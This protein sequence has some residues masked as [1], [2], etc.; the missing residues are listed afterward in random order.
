VKKFSKEE[1]SWI[2]YDWANSA[3]ATIMLAA[4]FPVFFVGM[5]G[6]EGTPGSMW[7]A[8]GIAIARLVLGIAAPVIGA[9]IAYKGYKMR[10]FVT[11]IS[12][13][14][15]F[16]LFL[17]FQ[18][19]WQMLLVGYILA[20]IF[21]SASNIIYD[22]YLPDVTT[23]DRMDKVSA[24]GY[25]MG[26]I[27]GSTI[28]F[29]ISIILIMFGEQFPVPIDNTMAVRISIVMTA[30]WWGIFSIP[31]IRDVRHKHG[32]DVPPKGMITDAFKKILATARKIVKNKG[33][34]IFI[35]AY[36]FYIDGVGTVI[37]IATAYGAELGLGAVGMIGALFVMQLVAMP[38]SILFG[39]LADRF[40]SINIIIGAICIYL[41]I[42]G[43]GFVMGFGMEGERWFGADVAIMMFWALA[44]M[45]GTVQGGIQATSRAIY[46]RLI[47]P[48]N[49]GEY[50][51][52]F[53]IFGRFAAILGPF[54]YAT[55]LG[56][57]GRPYFAI[58]SIALV[59]IVGLVL[60]LYGRKHLR[61]RPAREAS[62]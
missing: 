60:L 44:F 59:F 12:L 48:E 7:W 41:V 5:A 26:Y 55:I 35:I 17:A 46:A 6:G 38:F 1:R 42:C 40:N 16:H 8:R 47:P 18:A 43:M 62:A 14:I 39:K 52:F 25:A 36:F 50:F 2:M 13:G 19:T 31:M 11:F 33:L 20:N 4:V 51:G 21:W 9:I 30:V 15:L 23:K 53:E 24:W 22:S 3:F 27:G 49:S 54:L 61:L 37:S 45:V 10:L 29:L 57:T 56:I 32:V 28:P 58:L 34:F